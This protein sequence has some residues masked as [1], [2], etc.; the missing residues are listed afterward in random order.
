MRRRRFVR[1]LGGGALALTLPGTAGW[2]LDRRSS[3]PDLGVW[4]GRSRSDAEWLATLDRLASH[5]VTMV[6]PNV[7]VGL[8]AIEALV[9]PARDRGIAV[10]AWKPVM[11]NG[12]MVDERPEWYAVSR[13]GVSTAVDPPYVDYYRFLCPTRPPVRAWLADQIRELASIPGLASVH[14]DYIRFPDVILPEALW[15]TYDLLQDREYPPFDFCYC[16]ACRSAFQA[17]SGYDPLSLPDPT[18]D[19]PW[20]RFRWDAISR[21]VAQLH[22]AARTEGTAVTA[23]VFPTPAIARRLVRQDWASWPLDGVMPMIYNGFYNEPVHWIGHAAREGVL[24]LQRRT[25]GSIPLNAGIYVPDLSPEELA[26]GAELALQAGAA[27]VVLFDEGA[28]TDAHW[29]AVRRVL[30]P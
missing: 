25:R 4:I 11:M 29:S 24:A 5:G 20:R 30:H 21:V 12:A 19:E 14:L 3:G 6:L 17:E 15:P 18:A 9:A 13:E 26:R 8:D 22:D 16:D 23:A 2:P 1:T 27:G 28:T 10:H 7:G